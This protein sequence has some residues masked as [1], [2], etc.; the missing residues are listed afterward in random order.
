MRQEIMNWWLQAQRDVLTAG[1]SLQSKD[2]YAC[3]F[4]CQ[5]ALEKGLKAMI[6]HT[7]RVSIR[8]LSVHSLA[9]LGV[10]AKVPQKFRLFLRNVSSEYYL[11]RYPDA[12]EAV[13][14][15]LYNDA[16]AREILHQAQEVMQ[17]LATHL[18]K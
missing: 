18:D 10:Y 6:M 7:K 1:H 13:P 3:V 12:S 17:W 11:S 8:E 15:T 14:Y 16:D 2:Y 5:Q 4:W 9:T